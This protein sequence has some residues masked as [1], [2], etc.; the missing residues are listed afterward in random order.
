MTS[1]NLLSLDIDSISLGSNTNSQL[2]SLLN[3]FNF[4]SK[5]QSSENNPK[6][7]LDFTHFQKKSDKI[8]KKNNE[9]AK[10][11][12][13]QNVINCNQ[14]QSKYLDLELI[15]NKNFKPGMGIRNMNQLNQWMENK[16]IKPEQNKKTQ[17]EEENSIDI[18]EFIKKNNTQSN[19]DE[20][21]MAID[22][23]KGM[24]LKNPSIDGNTEISGDQAIERIKELDATQLNDENRYL[25]PSIF[26]YEYGKTFL[27]WLKEN[28][29]SILLSCPQARV[30]YGLGAGKLPKEDNDKLAIWITNFNKPMGVLANEE[31]IWLS[32]LGNIWRYQLEGEYDD[33]EYGKSDGNYV[34]RLGYFGPPN[35]IRDLCIDENN[36][37]CFI[38]LDT[39]VICRASEVNGG[40]I[41]WKM[42][43]TWNKLNGLAKRDGVLRYVTAHQGPE[44][45]DEGIVYDL[46]EKRIV[47]R[48]LSQPNSPFWFDNK[49]WVLEGGKGRIGYVNLNNGTFK[50]KAWLPGYVRSISNVRDK[51]LVVAC[52]RDRKQQAF[53]D[54]PLG[55][56]IKDK[57][58][59]PTCGIFFFDLVNFDIV[60]SLNIMQPIHEI[61]DCTILNG[62]VRPRLLELGDESNMRK[63]KI[64]YGE[65][66]DEE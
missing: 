19:K 34:P 29:C 11:K 49:L 24:N 50:E 45:G 57:M 56:I 30:F 31:T 39:N 32:S 2:N 35:R 17:L 22:E 43:D 46:V 18:S 26:N 25:N 7:I 61:Y 5:N 1:Q 54:L 23:I 6:K 37:V 36:T 12:Y 59:I 62:V 40:E 38:N 14:L 55:Q 3:N 28:K 4:S 48:G 51:Y 10:E 21:Q 27:T 33:I 60:E 47:C 52:S 16:G 64:D 63:Y 9:S 66:A 53:A 41:I 8:M 13:I 65:Y 44:E 58:A 42:P 15:H 20:G